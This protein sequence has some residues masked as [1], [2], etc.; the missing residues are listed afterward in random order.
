[1]HADSLEVVGWQD[2][3]VMM[4][5]VPEEP[6]P[7][8]L[9]VMV[10][11]E[12]SEPA[13][14]RLLDLDASLTLDRVHEVLQ[15][16]VGWRDA[17]L[18]S[19]TDTD[20]YQRVRPVNGISPASRR[21]VSQDLLEDSDGALPE[22]DFTIGA[23]LTPGSGPVF[24]EYDFGDSWT[25]RLDLIEALPAPAGAPRARLV[26][27]ARRAPLED[28]GGID[29]YHELLDALTDPGHDDHDD[30]TAWVAWTA[31]P[32]QDFAPDQLDADGVNTELT[33]LFTVS[34]TVGNTVGET[35]DQPGA[36]RQPLVQDITDRLPAGMRREFRSYLNTADLDEP[37]LVDAGFAEAMTAP[38]S[39]LIRRI[40][41][42][43]LNLT[44]A[45]WLPP[46]VVHQA[47]VELGWAEHWPGR[48]N[49]EDQTLPILRL[50]KSAQRLR[51]IRRIKG[52]LVLG[53]AAKR[54]LEDP[55]GLW[56][57]LA[58][59]LTNRTRHDAERDAT[60]LLLIE[61]AVGIHADWDD[62]LDAV[63]FG[64]GALGW[65]T[66]AGT[67][68]EAGDVHGLLSESREAL[69]SLGIHT[70]YGRTTS[71]VTPQGCTFVRAALHP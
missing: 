70:G 30:L 11:L 62:C 57:F 42:D 67:E 8:I 23:V 52:R 40:G 26:D 48:A 39:W 35:D 47:M 65:R 69:R 46:A 29:G 18:H 25:H 43:G 19:F 36:E 61:I 55:V 60:V 16:A 27:G 59:A 32:W 31:G 20:P 4:S 41:L 53:A 12:G 24:Y 22:R 15:V 37:A 51:L 45:G 33:R 21:W 34:D 58:H 44:A 5:S 9:R 66:R 13:I 68:L 6:R 10:S 56:H 71:T 49:R 38:Y 28:S 63:A 2:G 7:M 64:L 1:M 50:R 14:W 54:L 3:G 17:H